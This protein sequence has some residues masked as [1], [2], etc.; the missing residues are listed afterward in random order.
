MNTIN[1]S[2]GFSPFQLKTGRSP[3]LI[4]PLIPAPADASADAITAQE[5]IA[6]LQTDVKEAQDNLLAAKVRQAYHANEHRGAED[7]YEVG[8]LVMLSTTHRR[9]NY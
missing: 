3:R 9:R 6:R 1:T 8:D 2:T 5:I 7:I 4:P